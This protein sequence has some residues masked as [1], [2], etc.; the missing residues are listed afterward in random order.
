MNSGKKVEFSRL[1]SKQKCTKIGSKFGGRKILEFSRLNPN[2]EKIF[3]SASGTHFL[4][5]IW[6]QPAEIN[7]FPKFATCARIREENAAAQPE[8]QLPTNLAAKHV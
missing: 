4:P 1:N 8:C 3:S 2:F 7:F 6:V 5:Q